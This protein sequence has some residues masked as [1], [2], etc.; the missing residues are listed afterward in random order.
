MRSTIVQRRHQNW[1][2]EVPDGKL[3]LPRAFQPLLHALLVICRIPAEELHQSARH[4]QLILASEHRHAR[5]ARS[6]VERS[7][8]KTSSNCARSAIRLKKRLLVVPANL[9]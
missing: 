5:E 9:V 1:V 4:S 2:P 3:G 6:K 8:Q 7:R